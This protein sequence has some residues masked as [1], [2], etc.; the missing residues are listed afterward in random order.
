[1]TAGRRPKPTK[2]RIVGGNAGHRPLNENE[3]EPVGDLDAPPVW[4][5]EA[6]RAEWTY[7]I[8]NAPEGLLRKLDAGIFATWVV[9]SVLHREATLIVS[10]EGMIVETGVKVYPEDH[11]DAGLPIAG[12]GYKMQNPAIGILNK[13]AV[14]MKGAAAEMGFTPSSRTKIGLPDKPKKPG[15]FAGLGRRT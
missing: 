11:P 12:T 6:Q 7:A 13:Q 2:L 5:N 8:E 15:G 14:I 10:V 9:A 4:M 1:M 3:P